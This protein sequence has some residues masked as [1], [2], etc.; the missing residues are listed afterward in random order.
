MTAVP[1]MRLSWNAIS[2]PGMSLVLMGLESSAIIWWCGV[3][4]AQ[5]SQTY[6]VLLQSRKHLAAMQV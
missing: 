6:M 1:F 2:A 5:R 4:T 3:M